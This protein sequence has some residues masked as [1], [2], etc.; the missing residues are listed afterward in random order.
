VS[1]GHASRLV[2][3]I[4]LAAPTL[5]AA[6]TVDEIVSHHVA[7]RGGREALA[8]VRTLR[9]TGRV[10][11]PAGRQ[12][13]V[14]REIARPGRIRTE[15]V[16]QGT[17]GIYAWDG[18]G[19]WR[20]SPLEGGFVPA[21]LPAEEAAM[22]AELAD[23]DGPLVDWRTKGHRVELVGT[24]PLPGGNA[25]RLKLTLAKTGDVRD[26]WLDAAT[27]LVVRTTTR[28]KLLGRELAIE[29]VFDDY[30]ETGGVSFARSIEAGLRGR[31][32]R[33]RIQVDTVEL[34]PVLDDAR[35]RRPR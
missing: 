8:K 20:V 17:T 7:A 18:T 35:F 29:A 23:L 11:G 9:M 1:A 30:R 25:Y 4:A 13:L 6:Q 5:A 27:G 33:L 31:A 26:V 3:A 21:P 10:T 22:A 32:E 19:G 28:R 24:E 12:A 15:F 16:F 34:N 2:L 14:R